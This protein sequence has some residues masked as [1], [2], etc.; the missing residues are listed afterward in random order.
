[1]FFSV[2]RGRPDGDLRR[3][4]QSQRRTGGERECLFL[5]FICLFVFCCKH[6]LRLTESIFKHTQARDRHLQ[7]SHMSNIPFLI[8][9]MDSLP[10]AV[11]LV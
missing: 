3:P 9:F 10:R 11:L 6:I 7:F 5:F 8:N 1:M 2:L 4:S